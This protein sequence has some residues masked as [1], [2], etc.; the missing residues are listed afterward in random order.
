LEANGESRTG[1]ISADGRFVAFWSTATNLVPSDTNG[2]SDLFVHDRQTGETSRISVAAAGSEANHWSYDPAISADGRFVAFR[3]FASN[4][5]PDD[6]NGAADI[7]VHDR[8]TAQTERISL[9]SEGAQANAPSYSLSISAD[10]FSLAFTSSATNLVPCDAND[11]YDAFV[12]ERGAVSAGTAS[13]ALNYGSG[14]PGSYFTLSGTNFPPDRAALVTANCTPLGFVPVDATGE[15]QCLL[16]ST[17]AAEGTYILVEGAHARARIRLVLD[18]SLPL[19]PQESDGPTLQL[20]PG[21]ALTGHH[22]LP[23]VSRQTSQR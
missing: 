7:F 12:H 10:G 1:S 5:V 19:R 2:A 15:L 9:S 18:S 11:T 21:I 22:F 4:L 23:T 8:Q 13:L 16:Q 3:S 14:T 6:T 20:P 17:G